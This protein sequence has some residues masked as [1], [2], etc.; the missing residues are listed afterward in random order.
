MK[1]F[2]LAMFTLLLGTS[3]SLKASE[4]MTLKGPHILSAGPEASVIRFYAPALDGYIWSNGLFVG[5]NL[6]YEHLRPQ[7]LY[8]GLDIGVSRSAQAGVIGSLW[9]QGS[10]VRLGYTF[11]SKSCLLSPWIG[12]G[13]YLLSPTLR[14]KSGFREEFPYCAGGLRLRLAHTIKSSVGLN[15]KAFRTFAANTSYRFSDHSMIRARHDSWGG[16][17]SLPVLLRLG[18]S[19]ALG[20]QLEPYFLQLDWSEERSFFGLKFLLLA[21]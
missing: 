12:A 14:S 21:S 6:G 11:A 19:G 3:H 8:L 15:L 10:E 16:Q 5:F 1:R 7:A 13:G 4:A 18:S 17:V 20:F 9:F 2:V